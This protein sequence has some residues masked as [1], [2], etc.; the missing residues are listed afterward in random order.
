MNQID[1]LPGPLPTRVL[2]LDG[3]RGVAVLAVVGYHLFPHRLPGGFLGVDMFFVLSG[4]LITAELVRGADGSGRPAFAPFW[5]RRARRLLP[6]LLAVLLV[7]TAATGLLGGALEVRL[8]QQVLA[9]LTFSSNWYQAG[10]PASYA[11]RYEAPVL[12]HL[13]SLAVEEQFYLVWPVLLWLLL[14]LTRPFRTDRRGQVVA[15]LAVLGVAAMAVGH[16]GG[17]SLN[18]LYFG[19]DTHGFSL[20]IGAVAALWTV[21]V[22]LRTAVAAAVGALLAV[23]LLPWD[24]SLTYLGGTAAVAA[25]TALVVLHVT[26]DAQR[27]DCGRSPVAIVLSAP[28]LRWAGRRSYGIYLWHWPVI[29]V[30]LQVAP[31]VPLAVAAVPITLGLA[32][33]SWRHLEEPVQ[34]LGYRASARQ[35]VALGQRTGLVGIAVSTVVAALVSATV[36]AGI[37]NSRDHSALQV[38]LDT[39]Q[40]AIEA[41]RKATTPAPPA[42]AAGAAPAASPW[43]APA[44]GDGRDLTVIGDSV[45]VAAAPA[46]FDLLPQADVRAHVGM[47]MAS[48]EGRIRGLSRT[49]A[50]RPVVVIALGTNGDFAPHQLTDAIGA[51]GPGH[52]FVLV[53]ASGPRSWIGPANAK[54]R[55]YARTHADARL[56]DWAAL[57]SRVPD[58]AGDRIHPGPRGG[59]VLARLMSRTAASFYAS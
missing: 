41:H 57:R 40:A 34:R 46:L 30:L 3:L 7:V 28:L 33:L 14:A 19:T 58:F 20:L 10:T 17:A 49:G 51:A 8:R 18:R 32:A 12:Q 43:A 31:G 4:F 5:A 45:T 53:T 2:A 6:A 25:A 42:P 24:A 54:L 16:L 50:L 55:H 22:R 1:R 27:P 35:V 59:A 15:V 36:T 9:A 47:Q 52:R 23:V 13:W 39:G 26:A 21:E 38:S 44:P 56:A 48:L 37:G 29:V 11:D